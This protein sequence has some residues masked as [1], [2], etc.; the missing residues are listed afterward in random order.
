MKY[1]VKFLCF[2]VKYL[3]FALIDQKWK[4][5]SGGTSRKIKDSTNANILSNNT[6][7]NENNNNIANDVN[8]SNFQWKDGQL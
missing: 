7:K 5:A 6:D 8:K 3:P 4:K 2:L 1:C